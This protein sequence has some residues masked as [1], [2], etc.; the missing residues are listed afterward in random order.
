VRRTILGGTTAALAALAV[1][2]AATASTAAKTEH[3]SF[4]SISNGNSN[5]YSAIATGA[6]TAGGTATLP[7]GKGTL[8]FVGCTIKVTDKP[9]GAGNMNVDS[10]TCLG[11]F[12]QPGTYKIISGTGIYAGITGSGK[13]TNTGTVVFAGVSGKCNENVNSLASQ[14]IIKATGPW[15]CRGRRV[16]RLRARHGTDTS[17]FR[18]FDADR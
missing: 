2:G 1:A 18:C 16:G 17:G 7:Q 9:V 14:D 11:Y 6:F 12:A 15:R 8:H 10:A 5:V 13:F 4:I 3:F